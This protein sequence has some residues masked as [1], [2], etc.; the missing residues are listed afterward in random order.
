MGEK[1]L[2]YTVCL[3]I[4]IL[5]TVASCGGQA[6]VDAPEPDAN[7]GQSIIVSGDGIDGE[8]EYAITELMDIPGAVFEHAF[9]TINNWP[10]AKFYAAR[11]I[12]VSAILETAGVLETVER[13][14]FLSYDSYSVTLTRKQLFDDAQYYFPGVTEGSAEGAVAVQPVIAYEY[15]AGT[16]DLNVALPDGLCLIIGQRNHMEQTNPAF[17]ENLKEIIVSKEPAAKWD[18]ASIFPVSGSISAGDNIKLQHPEFGLVKLFYTLDGAEP[19]E[20]SVMYNPSTYQPELNKPIFFTESAELKV[21]VTGFGRENSD[22][23]AFDIKVQ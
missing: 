15:K 9:S 22:I 3:T 21:L 14:T 17:V 16:T 20:L 8:L 4:L 5:L 10:T 2:T 7:G 12:T 18:M 23:A 11:G 13:V 19:T 1:N 6:Q